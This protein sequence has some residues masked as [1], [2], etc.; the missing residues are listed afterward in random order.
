MIDKLQYRLRQVKV[1][2]EAIEVYD[3]QLWVIFHSKLHGHQ[4]LNIFKL[5]PDM[6]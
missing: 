6:F 2:P 3:G 5:D 1:D 4:F